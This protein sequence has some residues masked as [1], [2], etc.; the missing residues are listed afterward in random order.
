MIHDMRRIDRKVGEAEAREI[1]ARAG[2]GFLATVGEDGWPYAVPVNHVL[3]GDT[4][5]FHCALS[6]HKLDNL[7]HEPRVAY[8]AVASE[9]I[10]PESVTT[11][12][13]SAIA[14]GRAELILENGERRRALEA[15]AHRFS[16]AHPEAIAREM[17]ENFE[18]TAV[19]RLRIEH[20]SG[21]VHP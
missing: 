1:M 2:H 21:K 15:L 3:D 4:L 20:L 18:R 19:I 6:G 7:G 17:T 16:A 13:E 14:F 5:Y 10:I 9:R 8:S 12:Y 11:H